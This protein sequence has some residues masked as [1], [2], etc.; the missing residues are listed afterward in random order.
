[1]INKYDILFF[2]ETWNSKTTNVDIDHFHCFSCPRPKCNKKAKRDSGGVIIYYKQKYFGYIKLI[3]INTNGLV[4]IK[5]DKTFFGTDNDIYICSCYIPPE[6]SNV[7]KNINSQ[8]FEFDFFELL[9]NDIRHYSELGDILITGDLN[10]RVGQRSDIVQNINLDRFVDMP[11]NDIPADNLP[12]RSS[13]DNK[14][15]G[16]GNKLLTVCKENSIFIV[17]GRKEV[18]KFTCYNL[19][20]NRLAAS[21]VDYVIVNYDMFQLIDHFEVH[22]LNEFSDHCPLHFTINL[23]NMKNCNEN[24]SCDKIMW[25]VSKKEQFLSKLNDNKPH[26]DNIVENLLNDCVDLNT[27]IDDFSTLIYDI[28]FAVHGKTIRITGNKNSSPHRKQSPWFDNTC[29]QRKKDFYNCKRLYTENPT[30]DNRLLFLNARA[31]YCKAKRKAKQRYS[32]IEKCT[33]ATLSKTNARSF[34]KYINKYKGKKNTNSNDIS[35]DEFVQHFKN[36]SNTPH[37]SN[38]DVND[39]PDSVNTIETNELDCDFTVDEICK[40]ISSLKRNKSCDTSNVVADFFIDSKEFIAPYLTKLFNYIFQKGVY[41]EAWSKGAIVPIF[42]KGDRS[43]PANYRGITLVNITAKIFSLVLRNR[44][45]KWCENNNVYNESQFGFRNSHSTSDCIFILHALIQNTILSKHKLYCAFV[46]YEKAFDTVIHDALWVKLVE[47]GVSSKMINMIKSIYRSVKA[48]IKDASNMS[49]SDMFDISLGVKQGEPLSPLLFILFINDVK[50]SVDFHNLTESDIDTLSIFMLLFADD[51]A[52][53]TTDPVSLQHQ[54]NSLYMYSCNWGL[55]INIKKTKICVFESRKSQCN[56]RWTINDEIV[57]VVD[58]FCYLGINFSYTGNMNNAVKMLNEQALKAYNHLLSV[59]SRLTLDIK[60]KLSLFD[61][62]IVPI[63]LYGSEIW[64]AYDHSELD[65]LHLKFCKHILG[66]K[67][68]TS[69]A[70]VLGELGRFPLSVICKERALKYWIKI[71][72]NPNS[73]MHHVLTKQS[74]I[75]HY[76][77]IRPASKK[78]WHSA[79]SD[80][81]NRMGYGNLLVD[82]NTDYNYSPLLTQR[83][84]DQYIQTWYDNLTSQ[85]KMEYYCRFKKEFLFEEYLTCVKNDKH[86]KEL[87]RFRLSSHS[88]EIETGR[89]TNINRDNRKCKLCSH[90]TV[91]SEYHFLLCCTAY[92]D[93]R[94]KYHIKFNWPNMAKFKYL[95]SVKRDLFLQNLAKFIYSAMKLRQEKLEV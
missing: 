72:M 14:S 65:K 58:N 92:S 93:L 81:L 69:N 71:N 18:G 64:G 40:I 62:L 35:I 60:T 22:D 21:V 7:Y 11:L 85:P 5:L 63:I 83:V 55:K 39:Y 75:Y 43:D 45:D 3:S 90:D 80:L 36:M 54:L 77:N 76:N 17:N 91:E 53:F 73:L 78:I 6:D 30:P 27:C 47:S 52:L 74:N 15:N 33:L 87:S 16:F 9:S 86:R 20:R 68:Q 41:P 42:K 31:L 29:K 82:F 44:I 26:F 46:D 66:V 8:L 38:F 19:I 10:S 88:L 51:I 12:K 32:Y 48:C 34:W 95:M 50:D 79:M 70:A 24:F 13:F 61:A 23:N 1:M 4:W 25:D 56:F 2:S 37:P 94:K 89:Y 28:S 84:R 57:E 49:Y 59:F 67:Q